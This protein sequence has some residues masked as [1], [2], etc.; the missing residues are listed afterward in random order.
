LQAAANASQLSHRE[1]YWVHDVGRMAV[2]KNANEYVYITGAPMAWSSAQNILPGDDSTINMGDMIQ[3][4]GDAYYVRVHL[5]FKTMAR[6]DRMS[7]RF[8]IDLSIYYTSA[9]QQLV[10]DLHVVSETGVHGDVS[11]GVATPVPI[12]EGDID[13]TK[14]ISGNKLGLLVTNNFEFPIEMKHVVQIDKYENI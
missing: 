5:A 12:E 4:V 7:A 14:F 11:G 6:D 13:V 2:G 9:G 8:I 10:S 3:S 1:P